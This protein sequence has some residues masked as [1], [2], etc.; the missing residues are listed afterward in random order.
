MRSVTQNYAKDAYILKLDI[1]GYFM[2]MDTNLLYQ[3]IKR[4]KLV[5]NLQCSVLEKEIVVHLIKEVIFTN[6]IHQCKI[7]GNKTLWK[8]IP[9]NKSLFHSPKNCG[10]PIGNYTSQIFGNIYLNE[11]DHWLKNEL[12]IKHYSRYV[13]D[14]FFMHQDNGF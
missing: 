5:E 4:L 6:P 14:M 12:G 3:Q 1:S 7:V 2:N 13:D 8:F 11:F 9:K 10:L